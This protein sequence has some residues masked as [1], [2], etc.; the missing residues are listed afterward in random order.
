MVFLQS[1]LLGVSLGIIYDCFRV[2]REI[3]PCKKVAVFFQDLLF[4]AIV[5]LCTLV[6]WVGINKGQL[7]L[8]LIVGEAFG[9]WL[10]FQSISRIVFWL[11][12]QM[13]HFVKRF[14]RFLFRPIKRLFSRFSNFLQK[15][16]AQ[17]KQLKKIFVKN[18]FL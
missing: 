9:S 3:V 13:I 11:V 2:F 7:R 14:L 12:C 10:Y 1:C 15:K 16:T 8:Y 5:T 6:F 17:W 4:F 18:R